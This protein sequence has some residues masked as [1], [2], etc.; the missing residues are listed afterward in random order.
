MTPDACRRCFRQFCYH[1]AD[2]PREFCSQLHELCTHWLKP[3]K[4]TKKEILDLVILE[5]FLAACHQEMQCW[6]R[7]CEPETTS[8]AVA[9]AEGFLLSQAQEKRQAEQMWGRS[10]KMEAKFSE[11]E[12]SPSEE[13]QRVHAQEH[14]QDAPSSAADV[15]ETV[16]EFQGFSLEKVKNED[17]EG[18]CGDGPQRQ[19]GSQAGVDQR[20]EDEEE[21]HPQLPREVKNEDLR[22]NF[23]NQMGGQSLK[24]EAKSSEAEGS[25]SEESQRAQAQEHAQDALSSGDAQR[26]E[27]DEEL[28]PQLPGEV[29]NENLRGNF[30]NQHQRIHTGEKPFDCSECG[31]RF[32]KIRDVQK[33]LRTHRG[34]KL[35]ECPNG[36]WHEIAIQHF[37]EFIVCLVCQ[38]RWSNEAF[39]RTDGGHPT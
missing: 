1:E 5:K 4:N 36:L 32:I 21:L 19:E 11:A 27:E 20:N 33:H 7:G 23:R 18:H 30:S 13:S 16:G 2:G 15:E 14:A 9:L 3:E 31:K 25:P 24:M 26:N 10:M 8:Q 38:R 35:F 17:A 28:H 34:E 29:R 12:G 22:R 37:K 6:V 39:D